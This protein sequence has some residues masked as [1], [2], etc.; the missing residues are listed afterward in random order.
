MENRDDLIR[1]LSFLYGTMKASVPLLDLAFEKAS[2]GLAEYFRHHREE[3]AGH[4]DML[5]DD[6]HRLGVENIVIPHSATQCAGSQYYLIHH[7]GP[8]LLLGYIRVL[9]S[10]GID[11]KEVD[12]LSTLH[13]TELTCL[14]HH[15][16][17]DPEHLQDIERMIVSMPDKTRDRIAWNEANT[18]YMLENARV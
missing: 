2:G 18:R 11:P 4:D 9:E 8:E 3:E 1:I 10:S 6:L 17:H 12:R 13:G 16:M 14:K 7:E 5:R 15:A